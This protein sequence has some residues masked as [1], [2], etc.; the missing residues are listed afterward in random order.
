MHSEKGEGERGGEREKEG[1]R[2]RERKRGEREREMSES[3][4]FF[5]DIK[6][7]RPDTERE[8]EKER[9]ILLLLKEKYGELLQMKQKLLVSN[10]ATILCM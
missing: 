10:Y 2:E 8:R 7:I 3:Y 1:K 6:E 9:E 5:N 4:I